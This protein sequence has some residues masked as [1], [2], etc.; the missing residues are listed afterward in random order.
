MK[1]KQ[2]HFNFRSERQCSP[3][4]PKIVHMR[5]I[6]NIVITIRIFYSLQFSRCL[7]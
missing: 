2:E 1:L 5:E 4:H 3:P 7:S 6:I